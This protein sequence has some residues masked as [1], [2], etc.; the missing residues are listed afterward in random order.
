MGLF[1]KENCIVC[2]GEAVSFS[3]TKMN[4]G[5]Y[6]CSKCTLKTKLSNSWN[7]D[8]L[9]ASTVEQIKERIAY[10]SK[11]EI[12]NKERISKFKP[13]Q[14]EGGYIWFDDNNKWFVLPKGTFSS[15]INECFVFKYDEILDFEVLE[16]G[17][18]ITKGGLGK[19]IVGGAV[20]GLAGVIAGGTAKKSKQVCTKLEIK[21]TTKNIDNPVVY[22]NMIDTEL[23]KDSL[24]YKTVSRSVQ[25]ILSKFQIIVAQLEEEKEIEKAN[26]NNFI[27]PADEIKKF[28]E[29]LD[30]GA[31][32]Q[33]EFDAKKTQLLEL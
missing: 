7:V 32:T 1:S 11:A 31:I 25:N 5:T 27:S 4:N 15:K 21:I 10:A 13:T 8:K 19:A 14:K 17:N 12:E 22:L 30:I 20:F 24:L 28:K 29:L 23:K 3:R 33:E 2:G 26:T 18:T 6:I 9:K 16:D